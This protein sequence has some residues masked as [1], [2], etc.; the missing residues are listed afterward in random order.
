MNMCDHLAHHVRRLKNLEC[1]VNKDRMNEVRRSHERNSM[2]IGKQGKLM[3]E[4]S[5]YT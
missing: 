5:D 4:E 3:D 1:V 2:Q